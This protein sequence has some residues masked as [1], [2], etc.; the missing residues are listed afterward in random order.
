[1]NYPILP[2]MI[3]TYVRQ[4]QHELEQRA[5]LDDLVRQAAE[6]N[7]TG[8][9]SPVAAPMRGIIR[10]AAGITGLAGRLGPGSDT[11]QESEVKA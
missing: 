1:M 10:L 5:Q 2:G 9:I 8:R 7:G 3:D 4:H 6:A 11:R